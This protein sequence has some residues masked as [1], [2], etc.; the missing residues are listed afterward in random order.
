LPRAT[1]GEQAV[2]LE[3]HQLDRMLGGLDLRTGR[4]RKRYR[5]VT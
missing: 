5:R 4:R 1:C 2:E 3:Y